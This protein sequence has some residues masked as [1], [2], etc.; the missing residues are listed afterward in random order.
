MP[1][2]LPESSDTVATALRSGFRKTRAVFPVVAALYGV[3]LLV[4]GI[5]VIPF[6]LTLSEAFGSSTAAQGLS[7]GFDFTIVHDLLRFQGDGVV[8]FLGRLFWLCPFVFVLN[9]ILS[10][11]ILEVAAPGFQLPAIVGFLQGCGRHAG[12]F[13]ALLGVVI[14]LCAPVPLL[15]CT[16]LIAIAPDVIRNSASENV[17]PILAA[18]AVICGVLSAGFASLLMDYARVIL[19]LDLKQGVTGSVF[20]ALRF[21]S[22][23][24]SRVTGLQAILVLAWAATLS[25]PLML[26]LV[27]PQGTALLLVAAFL[28]HQLFVAVRQA[29]RVLSASAQL[30]LYHCVTMCA[31]TGLDAR[32]PCPGSGL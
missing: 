8:R 5:V 31:G 19:V 15:L 32:L 20:R 1:R 28:L 6:F 25:L 26:A 14:L 24:V 27:R 2:L 12:R 17:I 21:L 18:S 30:S 13:L 11:G 22:H 7:E 10:G 29:V 23:N 9:T 4:A 3:S 16:G